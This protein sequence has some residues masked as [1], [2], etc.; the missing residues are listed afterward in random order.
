MSLGNLTGIQP[1]HEK[2]NKWQRKMRNRVRTILKR[3]SK[4]EK[5]IK[6]QKQSLK[7]ARRSPNHVRNGNDRQSDHAAARRIV[8]VPRKG[9]NNRKTLPLSS[10]NISSTAQI[11]LNSAVTTA[12]TTATR[13][14]LEM[15]HQARNQ[16]QH[17][18]NGSQCKSHDECRP[19]HCCHQTSSAKVN[20]V[21]VRYALKESQTCQ[22]SCACESRLQCFR[23]TN[24]AS[25]TE[26]TPKPAVC[27]RASGKDV[28]TGV[29]ENSK[30]TIFHA[31]DRSRLRH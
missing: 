23:D 3:L 22:H 29:Y 21:C 25:T 5:R 17:G 12:S 6:A 15:F 4:L 16:S 8:V 2:L 1:E 28:E 11:A 13:K 7:S 14:R 26:V 30:Q 24:A 18:G 19:G 31:L 10:K 20:G 9:G 27:K